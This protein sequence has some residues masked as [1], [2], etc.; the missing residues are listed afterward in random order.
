MY[1]SLGLSDN[2]NREKNTRG[3]GRVPSCKAR[4]PSY[5]CNLNSPA[6]F[7]HEISGKPLNSDPG[8]PACLARA[9]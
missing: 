8:S 2:M 6:L 9:L 4:A 7:L 5:L 3:F 1:G